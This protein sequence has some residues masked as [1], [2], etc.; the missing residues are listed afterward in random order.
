MSGL[1]TY[2]IDELL[3]LEPPAWLID[4]T[5]P[6]GELAAIYGAPGDGKSFI[7]LD[8]ALCVAA[9][10]PW[11]G[12]VTQKAYVVYISA[13]GGRGIS[14]RVAAWLSHHQITP[15]QYSD[16]LAH[17]ITSA[18]RIHPDSED[19]NEVLSITIEHPDFQERLDDD[20]CQQRRVGYY[21]V[22]CQTEGL[23]RL[24]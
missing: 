6:E 1:T 18:V 23:R 7:A 20:V 19:L 3:R 9:G 16:V 24:S 8:M 17:F 11:Q 12:H 4:D 10:I 5:I 15:S 2:T 21:A 13:E 22:M 14:K